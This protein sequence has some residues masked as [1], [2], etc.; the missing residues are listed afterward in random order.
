MTAQV[1][2]FFYRKRLS[3]ERVFYFALGVVTTVLHPQGKQR[4][5]DYWAISGAP[6]GKRPELRVL[7]FAG[8][9][10]GRFPSGCEK[11]LPDSVQP[12]PTHPPVT[13]HR[14]S[15][16]LP[17][18]AGSPFTHPAAANSSD[19]IELPPHPDGIIQPVIVAL[20]SSRSAA[21]QPDQ[22]PKPHPWKVEGTAA[23]RKTRDSQPT[24]FPLSGLIR[25]RRRQPRS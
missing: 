5:Q 14:L 2:L 4:T 8:S 17:V 11:P 25:C 18:R 13:E 1:F 19:A 12:L 7:R 9:F 3:A 21:Q 22:R 24:A 16:P 15:D 23:L 6:T 20:P 10:L